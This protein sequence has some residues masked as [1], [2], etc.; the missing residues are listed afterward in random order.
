M[1]AVPLRDPCFV[2]HCVASTMVRIRLRLEEVMDYRTYCCASAKPGAK[3]TA[4]LVLNLK[5]KEECNMHLPGT[6]VDFGA[7]FPP[8]FQQDIPQIRCVAIRC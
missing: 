7:L 8:S 1:I 3:P 2:L 5:L 4:A 6:Y